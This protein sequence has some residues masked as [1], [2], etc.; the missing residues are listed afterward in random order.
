MFDVGQ[1][2]EIINY[3]QGLW[4]QFI[5]YADLYYFNSDSKIHAYI[6]NQLGIELVEVSEEQKKV[7]YNSKEFEEMKAWPSEESVQIIEGIL[8]IKL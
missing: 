2:S 1:W 3:D 6:N 5:G 8:I 4:G 7:I